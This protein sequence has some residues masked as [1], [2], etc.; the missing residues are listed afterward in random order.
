MRSRL[1]RIQSNSD[2]STENFSS[3][4]VEKSCPNPEI[5]CSKCAKTFKRRGG[6]KNHLKLCGLTPEMKSLIVKKPFSCY[7]CNHKAQCY[8]ALAQ[9]IR[10]RHLPRNPNWNKC[11]K[12][13]VSYSSKTNLVTHLAICG[14]PMHLRPPK[15]FSCDH[16]NLKFLSKKSVAVHIEAKHLPPGTNLKICE[17]CKKVFSYQTNLTRHLKSC[18]LPA[19]LLPSIKRFC[20][21]HCDYKTQYKQCLAVHIRKIHSSGQCVPR[22]PRRARSPRMHSC[23]FCDYKHKHKSVLEKHIRAKHLPPDPERSCQKCG[24]T[25]NSIQWTRIHSQVCGLPPELKL[26]YQPKRFSCAHCSYKAQK[27]AYITEHIIARHMPH[28]SNGNKCDKCGQQYAF[29]SSLKKH[30]ETCGMV[31][32]CAHCT[33]QYKFKYHLAQH[34][35]FRHLRNPNSFECGNCGKIYRV[36]CSLYAHKKKCAN[37][38]MIAPASQS[39]EEYE[40]RLYFF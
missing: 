29:R 6:L 40:E 19:H 23:F 13:G 4:E 16:C 27:K 5:K 10:A 3:Y 22:G 26:V 12:C 15:R 17:K 8:A 9:H 30:L 1:S 18:G 25:F 28:D 11:P 34:I 39:Y 20:C 36:R 21:D 31:F 35:R 38:P 33:N 2:T 14:I 7:H 37:L 32:S 24:K